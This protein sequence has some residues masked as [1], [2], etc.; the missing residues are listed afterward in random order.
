[1]KPIPNEAL[2]GLA[3]VSTEL[4]ARILEERK[5]SAHFQ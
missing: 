4:V 1:M 2:N 3:A 5:A